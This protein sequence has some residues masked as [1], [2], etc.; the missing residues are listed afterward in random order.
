MFITYSCCLTF[1][2]LFPLGKAASS[3]SFQRQ[4]Y[5]YAS[6]R[7]MLDERQE[8]L[9]QLREENLGEFERVVRILNINFYMPP[10]P[11]HTP[12][13]TRKEWC[14]HLVSVVFFRCF[15]SLFL[16]G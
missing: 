9:V 6:L 1:S 16:L 13:Q 15:F 5:R 8:N 11:D 2:L 3:M 10:V 4:A 14:E 12:L 7:K